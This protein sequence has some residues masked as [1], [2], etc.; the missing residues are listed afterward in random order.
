MERQ[1]TLVAGAGLSGM[2]HR[3]FPHHRL[4]PLLGDEDVNLLDFHHSI[5]RDGF[6]QAGLDGGCGRPFQEPLSA[7]CGDPVVEIWG[8]FL[9]DTDQVDEAICENRV[10]GTKDLWFVDRASEHD[11]LSLLERIA[12][13]YFTVISQ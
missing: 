4:E 12:S 5:K 6:A 11:W 13:V 9:K 8:E 7:A 2:V 10:F 1:H 3:Q